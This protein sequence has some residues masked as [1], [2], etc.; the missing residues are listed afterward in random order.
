M[1]CTPATR[2]FSMAPLLLAISLWLPSVA[3]AGFPLSNDPS[4][5]AVCQDTIRTASLR[6]ATEARRVVSACVTAG[7][8]CVV[9]QAGDIEGCCATAA[10]RCRGRLDRLESAEVRFGTYLR[11]RRCSEVPF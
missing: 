11:K 3:G 7:V 5:L 8:E 1:R 9:D 6:L 2:S 4:P 10:R